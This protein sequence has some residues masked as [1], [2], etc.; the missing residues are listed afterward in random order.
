MPTHACEVHV[1]YKSAYA[2]LEHDL[3]WLINT[4]AEPRE[5]QNTTNL[6]WGV[7]SVQ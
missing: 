5:Q 7:C 6:P 3:L 4:G 1:V 2:Y